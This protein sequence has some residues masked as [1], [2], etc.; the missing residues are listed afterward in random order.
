MAELKIS[1]DDIVTRS[2][3]DR[4]LRKDGAGAQYL[5]DCM[6]GVHQTWLDRGWKAIAQTIKKYFQPLE[7]NLDDLKRFYRFFMIAELVSLSS[8]DHHHHH[9]I[10]II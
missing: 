7:V 5:L 8:S 3:R 6:R 1:L 2:R 4:G 9:R 10:I